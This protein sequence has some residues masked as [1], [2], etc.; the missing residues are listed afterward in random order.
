MKRSNA[1]DILVRKWEGYHKRLS[2]DSCAAYPDVATGGEPWTIGYGTTYYQRAGK[3]KY[4]RTKVKQGDTLTRAQA[5]QE[6]DAELDQVEDELNR[7][8]TAPVTQSMM[9]SLCSFAFNCGIAGTAQQIARI[10]AGKYE[11]CARS[12]DLYI[13]ANG[14][15]FQGL[16]NR[17]NDEEAL[18][19]K[20][21]LNPSVSIPEPQ[22]PIDVPVST[23]GRPYAPC[24]VPVPWQSILARKE[25]GNPAWGAFTHGGEPVYLLQCALI[26]LGYLA[27]PKDGEF[28]GEVFNEHVEWA[29]KR[30]Q[31]DW[32][33]PQEEADGIVGPQTRAAIEKALTRAR[34]P[35][36]PV[37]NSVATLKRDGIK[38]HSGAWSGLAQLILTV[39]DAEFFVASGA[40]GRQVFRKADSPHSVPGSLEPIPQGIYR[41]DG[42]PE[43]A[44]ELD[45]YDGSW[46]NGLGPVW[47]GLENGQK[48]RR[49]AFG[50]HLDSNIGTARGSAGCIVFQSISELRRYVAA[51][52]KARP[53][54][55]RVDWNL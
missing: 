29:V 39:G 9:D 32:F 54:E 1:C 53:K 4:G 50:V 43:F 14:S 13:N 48:M 12:F 42:G 40:A 2:D 24:P 37:D 17:R 6:L 34:E 25:S 30:F 49:G 16:I 10:N 19:R 7:L 31:K 3:M 45:S 5:E 52:R 26:G 44:E 28:V 36:P 21:G 46:G 51:W 33:G 23:Q 11:A 15:P 22:P 47:H 20:D 55:L 35:K 41:F 18:F 38:T 27:K 8:I